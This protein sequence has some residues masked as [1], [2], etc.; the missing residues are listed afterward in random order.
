MNKEDVLIDFSIHLLLKGDEITYSE[1]HF[2]E[3]KDKSDISYKEY[4]KTIQ[5]FINTDDFV[6]DSKLDELAEEINSLSDILT[7]KEIEFFQE[8]INNDFRFGF[9]DEINEDGFAQGNTHSLDFSIEVIENFFKEYLRIRNCAPNLYISYYQ[10]YLEFIQCH[11]QKLI[12]SI[13]MQIDNFYQTWDSS[14]NPT[15]YSQL[16]DDYEKELRQKLLDKSKITPFQVKG[17]FDGNGFILNYEETLKAILTSTP[18]LNLDI[19]PNFAFIEYEYFKFKVDGKK[20]HPD[21]DNL[22]KLEEEFHNLKEAN[23]KQ[24]DYLKVKGYSNEQ[25][26]RVINCFSL[27]KFKALNIRSLRNL[28]HVD[29]YRLFFFFYRFDFLRDTTGIAFDE[30]KDFD[31]LPLGWNK[32]DSDQFDIKIDKNQFKKYH[33]RS[34]NERHEY[35]QDKHHPFESDTKTKKLLDRIQS[36]LHIELDKLNTPDYLKDLP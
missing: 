23:R 19:E 12:E 34:L 15:L 36:E 1:L 2:F 5:N 3:K 9:P 8:Y 35:R 27:N 13:A 7:T 21:S 4:L 26:D 6:W 22:K 17:G 20:I 11:Y 14:H 30:Q 25:I 29:Y 18:K 24:I 10:Q 28:K 32:A 16:K 33:D 31:E